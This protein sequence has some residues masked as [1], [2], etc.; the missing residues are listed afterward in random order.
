M[1]EAKFLGTT[2]SVTNVAATMSNAP[3]DIEGFKFR[4]Y[5]GKRLHVH[6]QDNRH[7]GPAW[8]DSVSIRCSLFNKILDGVCELRPPLG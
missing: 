1:V 6:F 7:C 2:A 4:P 8:G 3:F 5:C